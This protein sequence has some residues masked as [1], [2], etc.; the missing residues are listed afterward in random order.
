MEFGF[1]ICDT[2]ST[3]C[4][5]QTSIKFHCKVERWKKKLCV[6]LTSTKDQEKKERSVNRLMGMPAHEE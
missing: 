6:E 4:A 5:R 1:H 2:F 3:V